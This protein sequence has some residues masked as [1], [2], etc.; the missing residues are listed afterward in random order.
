MNY[1]LK[2]I[3]T[4]TKRITK[5]II[6]YSYDNF[7]NLLTKSKK[8]LETNAII[9]T[10]TY[11][12][13]NSNWIDQLTNF[14]GSSITY[15]E[16]G[17]PL[18][19]GNSITMSWING[20]S[21]S[22]YSDSS[23]GLNISY[24]YNVNGIRT[25]KIVNAVETKYFLE[26][27]NIIYEKRE[28]DTIYYL[29]DSIGLIGLKYN[30]ST[31]YYI[32]NL[33]GDI[34]GI[35]DSSYNKIVSYEYDSWG[36]VLSVKD[37]NGNEISSSNHIGIIN[38]FRYRSYYYDNEI[39]LYYLNNRYYNP[40]W[41]RFLNPDNTLGTNDD[42]I[43]YNLYSYVSNNPIN[44]SDPTGMFFKKA[45]NWI[46]KTKREIQKEISN[47]VDSFIKGVSNFIDS[48]SRTLDNISKSFVCEGQVG[49]G[50][51]VDFKI[52]K[53]SVTAG[54]NKSIGYSN[55]DGHYTTTEI[56]ITVYDAGLGMEVRNYDN[57]Q[58]NSMTLPWEVWDD[59]NT[60]KDITFGFSHKVIEGANMVGQ[61]SSGGR[62]IGIELGLYLVGGGKFKIGFNI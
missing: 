19:I 51:E 9:K 14:N 56:G 47:T 40:E 5:L 8:N 41:C 61:T 17:N 52:G 53:L 50:A 27:S 54:G 35:L 13:S 45:W 2:N 44:N 4:Y 25:S 23:K 3:I 26:D 43:G 29:Y 7:G 62:F 58:G 48:A 34:I 6:E 36:K 60:V 46:K 39:G 42:Y 31:Y 38:P 32:K 37:Q 18:T 1:I 49:L 20:R 11:Q 59:P 12:Y 24:Q 15:D 55:Q 21:L 57:G 16:I 30:D 22:S 10:D 33:Q 28:N